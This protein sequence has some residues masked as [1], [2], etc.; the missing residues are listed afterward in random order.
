MHAHWKSVLG[1][2]MGDFADFMEDAT[3]KKQRVRLLCGI[4]AF[5]GIA[6]ISMYVV[7]IYLES[8]KGD[9]KTSSSP[10]NCFSKMLESYSESRLWLGIQ[11]DIPKLLVYLQL[12]AAVSFVV[13]T[14]FIIKEVNEDL[15][16]PKKGFWSY[17]LGI[18]AIYFFFYAGACVWP[19]ATYFYLEN[20][21]TF[22][23]VCTSLSLVVCAIA[24][25]FL[26][27]GFFEADDISAW[28]VYPI[29]I[30]A[31]VVVLADGIG[32]NARL[33]YQHINKPAYQLLQTA[34]TSDIL[35]V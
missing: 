1:K 6:V 22:I 29:I 19:L 10:C 9:S 2:L 27:A 13:L 11:K 35:K 23:C 28:I 4:N 33:I 31:S 8:K 32:W 34:Q 5:G 25:I 30:F 18:E 7:V 15:N 17:R 26:V 16:W 14:V 24:C 12:A 21:S 20:K 3:D